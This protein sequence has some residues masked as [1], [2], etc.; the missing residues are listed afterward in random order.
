M[1][2]VGNISNDIYA[3]ESEDSSEAYHSEHSF[4]KLTPDFIMDA[5]ESLGLLCDGRNFAL[6]SYEN[7]VWQVGI[8]ETTP[9]IAKF[10]RQDRWSLAQ[11][12]E[13]QTFCFDLKAQELPVVEPMVVDGKSLFHYQGF[14][15]AL[16]ERKGGHAPEL[17]NPDHLYQ[18]GQLLARF[19]LVGEKSDFNQR[20]A[21]NLDTFGRASVDHVL[22]HLTAEVD[23][24]QISSHTLENYKQIAEQ[25]I[26]KL[27]E[28]MPYYD[29]IQTLRVHGDCHGGN[30]LW[31]DDAPHFVDF[32]DARTAPAIQDIWMLLSGDRFQQ[33]GQLLEI[34][35]GYEEFKQFNRKEIG[36]IEIFRSLRLLHH[37]AWLAKRW[38]D[39]AFPMA[40][41][42][43]NSEGYWAKHIVELREQ[44]LLLDEEPLKLTP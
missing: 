9:I 43:F 36:M 31:R 10:Y 25:L 32:D 17:D 28:K 41:P 7:R 35:E 29:D 11:I 5:V 16:F 2:N 3:D 21:L 34:L 24:F 6:N 4:S 33:Q 44:L 14:D 19:H 37:A 18:L 27:V 40:F 1:G 38:S 22:T 20:P 13:E 42:W 30:M 12:E 26:A 15:F 8:D 23:D 39:P